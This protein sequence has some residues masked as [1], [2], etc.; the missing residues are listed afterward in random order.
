MHQRWFQFFTA[1]ACAAA[2]SACTSQPP[3]PPVVA[4]LPSVPVTADGVYQG[5]AFLTGA[6]DSDEI[7]CGTNIPL[8]LTVTDRSF[9]YV[10]TE[11]QVV[12]APVKRFLVQIGPDGGFT[13]RS[14]GGFLQGRLGGD[15]LNGDAFGEACRFHFAASKAG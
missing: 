15:D 3:A 4:A 11:Q 14:G 12:S 5:Y 13:S 1:V 6:N 9:T 2:L 8:T 7:L 10:L